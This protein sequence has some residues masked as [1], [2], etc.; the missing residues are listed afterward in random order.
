VDKRSLVFYLSGLAAAGAAVGLAASCS[1]QPRIKCTAGHGPFAAVYTLVD[2]PP[3]CAPPGEQIGVEA[4]NYP[5]PDGTNLDPNNGSVGLQSVEFT[6]EIG[7]HPPDPDPNRK[8]YAIGN[9]GSPEPGPDNFCTVPAITVAEQVLGPV[10]AGAPLPDGAPSTPAVPA[11]SAKYEWSGVRF[12]NEPRSPGTQLIAD[13]TYTKSVGGAAPC[14]AK[15]KVVGLW[16]AWPCAH[17]DDPMA[18]DESKCSPYPDNSKG[19]PAGAPISPDL[20]TRCDPEL[21]LCV[22]ARDPPAFK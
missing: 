11:F 4:F 14:T 6:D 20:L 13:L 2:G 15:V 7:H 21:K 18:I 9:W 17:D 1:D 22:L 3:G 5:L 8:P 16:P 19:R 12:Y 10:D